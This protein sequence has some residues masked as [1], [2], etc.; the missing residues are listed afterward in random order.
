M[1][2]Y[3]SSSI[4]NNFSL[5]LEKMV[6]VDHITF[7]VWIPLTIRFDLIWNKVVYTFVSAIESPFVDSSCLYLEWVEKTNEK[8]ITLHLRIGICTLNVHC[9]GSMSCNLFDRNVFF[10]PTQRK[11]NITTIE[12]CVSVE[13][14]NIHACTLNVHFYGSKTLHKKTSSQ[15]F[16][17]CLTN[18]FSWT[19]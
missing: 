8:C 12:P 18:Y 2:S 6:F 13:I 15:T 9:Y 7:A 14:R 11:A 16:V 1:R 17:K 4:H 5:T 19:K 10:V 3:Q